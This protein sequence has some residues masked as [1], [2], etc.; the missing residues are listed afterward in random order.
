MIEWNSHG[1][2]LRTNITGNPKKDDMSTISSIL[3]LKTWYFYQVSRAR[4]LMIGNKNIEL[5]REKTFWDMKKSD[6]SPNWEKTTKMKIE[7][8]WVVQLKTKAKLYFSWYEQNYFESCN[9]L[10]STKLYFESWKWKQ[11]WIKLPVTWNENI[12]KAKSQ[13]LVAAEKESKAS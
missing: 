2:F 7:R 4:M 5:C 6:M 9:Y 13:N 1:S 11:S 10:S 12:L 3:I 8:P